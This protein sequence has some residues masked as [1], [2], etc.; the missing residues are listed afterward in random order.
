M[1]DPTVCSSIEVGQ[2]IVSAEV[3]IELRNL[4][5]RAAPHLGIP[6][7]KIPVEAHDEARRDP[8]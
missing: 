8:L 2:V 3:L 1:I 5:D 7:E 4:L 6:L